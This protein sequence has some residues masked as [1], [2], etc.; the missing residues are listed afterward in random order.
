MRSPRAG[1]TARSSTARRLAGCAALA[2]GL[3]ACRG[4]GGGASTTSSATAPSAAPTLALATAAPSG[5]ADATRVKIDALTLKLHRADLCLFSSLGL[6][7][8]REAY[9]ASLRGSEPG[10]GKVPSFDE[11]SKVDHER[12]ARMCLPKLWNA[13]PPLPDLDRVMASFAPTMADLAEEIEDGSEYYRLKQHERDAFAKGKAHHRAIVAL[14]DKL[15]AGQAALAGAL[16]TYRAAH[17]VDPTKLDEGERATAL[18]LEPGRALTLALAAKAPPKVV[19]PLVTATT[20]AAKA[21]E[22]RAAAH[23]DDP[24]SRVAPALGAFV[25]AASAAAAKGATSDALL[26]E[27]TSFARL[28]E[29]AHL[30]R[31][32]A[33]LEKAK[34]GR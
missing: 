33:L 3:A 22:E 5:S 21:A 2:L 9:L 7:H 29:V 12:Q 11:A 1:R 4:G 18:A 34:T 25:T 6:R 30:A 31:A 8:L 10:P 28:L 14:F 24:W 19:E 27:T 16:D 17:P 23:P 26:S 13:E 15:D 20:A 32:T